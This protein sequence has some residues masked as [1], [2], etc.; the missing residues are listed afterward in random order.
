MGAHFYAISRRVTGLFMASSSHCV[1]DNRHPMVAGFGPY[2]HFF[3]EPPVFTDD[4]E[5]IPGISGEDCSLLDL[6][7]E[8]FSTGFAAALRTFRRG[9]KVPR[10]A[11]RI[12][13][14]MQL[15]YD[16]SDPPPNVE[17]PWA[18]FLPEEELGMG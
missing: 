8:G 14:E 1:Y 11:L 10:R 17:T 13:E 9:R 6:V 7:C 5:E 16:E 15:K 4:W 12:L 3:A 2:D 18:N